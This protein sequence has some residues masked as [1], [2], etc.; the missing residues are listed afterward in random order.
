MCALSTNF[1]VYRS[2]IA[3]VVAATKTPDVLPIQKNDY[4]EFENVEAFGHFFMAEPENAESTVQFD[5]E[6]YEEHQENPNQ[7]TPTEFPK[8]AVL[9]H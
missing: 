2:H 9:Y 6:D 7:E 3:D 1:C 4:E 5:A 8:I